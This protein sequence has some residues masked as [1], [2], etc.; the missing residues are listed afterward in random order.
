MRKIAKI[1]APALIAAIG[2]G[3]AIPAEAAAPAHQTHLA[4]NSNARVVQSLRAQIDQLQQRVNRND[5]R[6]RIS[7]REARS[8]RNDVARLRSTYNAYARNGISQREARVLQQRID[9]VKA[10]LHVERHDNNGHRG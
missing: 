7:E 3:A 8:L 10:R 2:M 4:A 9:A 6:G 1:I 5:W